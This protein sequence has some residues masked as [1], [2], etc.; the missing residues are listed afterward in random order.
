LFTSSACNIRP[1]KSEEW[2]EASSIL[3][4]VEVSTMDELVGL[5]ADAL[6]PAAA[7]PAEEIQ[8]TLADSLRN[9]GFSL[10]SGVAI[11][12]SEMADLERTLVCFV[13]LRQPTRFPT[14]DRRPLV[15]FFVIL[16]RADPHAHLLLL[17][18]L[19]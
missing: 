15:V 4:D 12:H 10:G 13:I 1:V 17:A 8:V 18:R 9:E 7:F 11:P 5:A 14:I 2:L 19:A 3:L 6:A 16:S